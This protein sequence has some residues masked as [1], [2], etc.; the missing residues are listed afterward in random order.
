MISNS[1]QRKI[2]S[3]HQQRLEQSQSLALRYL[4]DL[5]ELILRLTTFVICLTSFY[6]EVYAIKTENE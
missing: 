4:Q 3:R 2:I 1:K 6:P 5:S